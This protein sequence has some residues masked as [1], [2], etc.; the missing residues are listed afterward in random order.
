[1]KLKA[2]F[3]NPPFMT[4]HGKV[5]ECPRFGNV[6][7]KSFY[8]I[9]YFSSISPFFS[10]LRDLCQLRVHEA[11]KSVFLAGLIAATKLISTRRKLQLLTW[12]QWLL[13]F[14]DVAYLELQPEPTKLKKMLRKIWSLYC[15]QCLSVCSSPPSFFFPLLFFYI[16]LNTINILSQKNFVC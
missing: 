15:T 2:D 16:S 1:M 5:L 9:T 13:I 11:Q 14:M 12:Q 8:F 4:W 10:I 7:R 3:A 6:L